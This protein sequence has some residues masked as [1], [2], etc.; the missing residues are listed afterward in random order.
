MCGL[1]SSGRRSAESDEGSCSVMKTH[2]CHDGLR[3]GRGCLRRRWKRLGQIHRRGMAKKPHSKQQIHENGARREV[4][5][6][7]EGS[8]MQGL[9][10]SAETE[11]DDGTRTSPSTDSTEHLD[12]DVPATTP[13]VQ[14]ECGHVG[15]GFAGVA[16]MT[17]FFAAASE[18]TARKFGRQR[19]R[20]LN[21]LEHPRRK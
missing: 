19:R 21:C 5:M 10:R 14:H 20:R 13:N 12:G 11:F 4:V 6:E 18:L 2:W 8:R 9:K 16:Q 1:R 17:F 15:N 7:K 3:R